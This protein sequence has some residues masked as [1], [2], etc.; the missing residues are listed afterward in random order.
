MSDFRGLKG[1]ALARESAFFKVEQVCT[2]LTHLYISVSKQQSLI[3][4]SSTS[5]ITQRQQ[6]S[7]CT[8]LGSQ[9]TRLGECFQTLDSLLL[10]AGGRHTE[11][12]I[13]ASDPGKDRGHSRRIPHAQEAADPGRERTDVRGTLLSCNYL[14]WRLM[15]RF[16]APAVFP[17]LH[18]P[19]I[20]VFM[21]HERQCSVGR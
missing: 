9:H 4:S 18:T 13:Q 3:T 11:A 19:K 10:W 21:L 2:V 15:P 8:C 20:S 14:L 17:S 12:S 1:F 5:S 16:G 7:Q 6:S